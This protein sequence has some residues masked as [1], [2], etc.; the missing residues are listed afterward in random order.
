MRK[1]TIVT[2]IALSA[3]AV[4]ASAATL[5]G[6]DEQNNL[7]TIN[8]AAP[9]TT[10][11]SRLITGTEATLLALDFR[12]ANGQ[13]YGLGSDLRL[14]TINTAT[15][16]ATA[17]GGPLALTG[18]NFGFDFN[19]T[20][21]RIRIVSNT[22]ANY[23]INPNDGSIQLVA[24]PVAYGAGDPNAGTTPN[25]TALAYTPAAQTGN[26][27]DSQLYAIDSSGTNDVL[28][29][30][31]NN[32]GVLTTVGATG[33]NFGPRDS[34]DI[35]SLGVGYAQDGRGLYQV[36]L[37]TGAFSFLGQTD[38]SLFGLSAAPA[39]VPEPATWAMMIGGFGLVGSALRRRR[40]S[41]VTA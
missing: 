36:N 37:Q 33:V 26:T 2:A 31:A 3:V 27:A 25:V 24:T 12:S 18:T 39:A 22:G 1:M 19:P 17:I 21:D 4:P 8:S 40:S 23:V 6:V 29:R 32:T 5:F 38:R 30:L 13:L 16:A 10:V 11:S 41:A 9:G 34:F 15:A 14:Y 20:I 28:A 35:D 7:V